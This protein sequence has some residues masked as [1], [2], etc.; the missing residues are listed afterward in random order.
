MAKILN[1]GRMTDAEV[2]EHLK[3]LEN[4]LLTDDDLRQLIGNGISR[5]KEQDKVTQWIK[6]NADFIKEVARMLEEND[7]RILCNRESNKTNDS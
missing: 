4:E 5:C 7:R 3:K 1:D 2:K 6:E